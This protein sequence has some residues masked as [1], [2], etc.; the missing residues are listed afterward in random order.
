MLEVELLVWKE[1]STFIINHIINYTSY[2]NSIN[3]VYLYLNLWFGMKY[4]SVISL[5]VSFEILT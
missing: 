4:L 3:F 5:W 1:A 2:L